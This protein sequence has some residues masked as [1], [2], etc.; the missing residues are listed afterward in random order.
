MPSKKYGS[1]KYAEFVMRI[2]TSADEMEKLR[3]EPQRVM[4]RA[5]LTKSEQAII[6]SGKSD[7][8]FA[9][10]DPKHSGGIKRFNVK[11]FVE[12]Q[13]IDVRPI[14]AKQ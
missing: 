5:G 4:K 9:K 8:I 2:A 13:T 3:A 6:L 12:Q 1:K 14:A 7:A 11:A 10:I